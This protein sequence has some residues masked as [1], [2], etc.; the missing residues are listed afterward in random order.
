MA[1]SINNKFPSKNKPRYWAARVIHFLS[2]FAD[3]PD[4]EISLLVVACS[5]K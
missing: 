1:C 5:V 3:I 2:E 4:D